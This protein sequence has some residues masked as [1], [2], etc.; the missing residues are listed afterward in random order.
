MSALPISMA[1]GIKKTMHFN[2]VVVKTAGQRG[3]AGVSLSP[4]PTYN[5]EFDMDA[6]QGNEAA[7]TTATEVFKGVFAQTAGAAG[8]FLFTDPQDS[9][10]SYTNSAMLDVTPGSTTPMAA[11]GNGVSTVFQLG[12]LIGGVAYDIL[13]NVSITGLKVGATAK[14]SPG[15]YTVSSTGVVTFASAPGNNVTLTWVGTF[16]FLCRFAADEYDATRIYS[17]NSGTDLWDFAGIKFSS[18]LI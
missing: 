4:Y 13:Q 8:L 14:F 2:S 5:F 17:T 7:A 15:D 18:E 16:Q 10:V 12:R 6:V 3:N 9:A 11:V 1:K